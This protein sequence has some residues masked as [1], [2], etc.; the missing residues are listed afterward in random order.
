MD[1]PPQVTSPIPVTPPVPE[2]KPDVVPHVAKT[3]S[4][5]KLIGTGIACLF[6][7]VAI[8]SGIFFWRD[9]NTLSS[10]D[11]AVTSALLNLPQC[12][13]KDVALDK[14]SLITSLITYN[15]AAIG[16][17]ESASRSLKNAEASTI[18]SEEIERQK[19]ELALYQKEYAALHAAQFIPKEDELAAHTD[20]F[21]L[22]SI[23]D[24]SIDNAYLGILLGTLS[25]RQRE[26]YAFA[27]EHPNESIRTNAKSFSEY[28]VLMEKRI[29]ELRD[30]I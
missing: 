21:S 18:F 16:Q 2:S 1:M 28:K 10:K 24:A 23:D 30:R 7:G 27:L 6:L 17:L 5:S 15:T 13:D 19:K 25:S 3:Y 4:S 14:D 26:Y 11:A 12:V 20:S 22:S 9:L 8:T 29:V